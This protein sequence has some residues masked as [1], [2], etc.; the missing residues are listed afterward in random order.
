MV[1]LSTIIT[2]SFDMVEGSGIVNSFTQIAGV[3][4]AL[5]DYDFTAPSGKIFNGY[6]NGTNDY[7]PNNTVTF[8]E[9]KTLTAQ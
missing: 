4:F 7:W 2:V 6:S 3:A 8:D 5:P 1:D 9:N